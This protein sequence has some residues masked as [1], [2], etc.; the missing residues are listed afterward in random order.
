MHKSHQSRTL[1]CPLQPQDVSQH[2]PN[3]WGSSFTK[4]PEENPWHGCS[5]LGPRRSFHKTCHFPPLRMLR[6]LPLHPATE[7]DVEP[8]LPC[9]ASSASWYRGVKVRRGTRGY[10]GRTSGTKK[11]F[12]GIPK[13]RVFVS[14]TKCYLSP[15]RL[16]AEEHLAHGV[17]TLYGLSASAQYLRLLLN[18]IFPGPLLYGD[19]NK[20]PMTTQ[21]STN[22]T[23][24]S[25]DQ[26]SCSPP[27]EVYPYINTQTPQHLQ[28]CLLAHSPAICHFLY[29]IHIC[30]NLCFSKTIILLTGSTSCLTDTYLAITL[31]YPC[32]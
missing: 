7:N 11:G 32:I 20:I 3:Y 22:N 1:K 18:T 6:V 13:E 5:Q 30:S 27:V 9:K 23:Q 14:A 31:K 25:D 12:E 19:D 28:V 15:P 4:G 29:Q 10:P 17:R 24:E 26:A 8:L 2:G 16:R 21:V